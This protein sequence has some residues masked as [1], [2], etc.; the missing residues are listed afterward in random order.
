[1]QSQTSLISMLVDRAS[2]TKLNLSGFSFLFGLNS[3]DGYPPDDP[4]KEAKLQRNAE[5]VL[6]DLKRSSFKAYH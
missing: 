3:R 2:T 6:L 4:R 1:M 5:D